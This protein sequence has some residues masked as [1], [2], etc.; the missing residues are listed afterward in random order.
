M[1]TELFLVLGMKSLK[2]YDEAVSNF[3][4]NSEIKGFPVSSLDIYAEQFDKFCDN[5]NDVKQL[6]QLAKQEKWQDKFNLRHQIL[7][8]ENVVVVTDPDLNITFASQNMTQMNGYKAEEV[9]GKT[10]RMFQGE[11]TSEETKKR[12]SLAV[13][14]RKPFKEVLINYR[15]DGSTYKCAIQGSPVFDNTGKLVNFIAFE[16]EVA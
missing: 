2:H 14:Q 12:V 8:K 4:E 16:K 10:P 11:L 7:D 9:L 6:Y 15:K 13:K 5:L 1:P 3:Y